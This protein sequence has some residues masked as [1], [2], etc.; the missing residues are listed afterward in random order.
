MTWNTLVE[1]RS[2]LVY[3]NGILQNVYPEGVTSTLD[4]PTVPGQ[5]CYQAVAVLPETQQAS[6]TVCGHCIKPHRKKKGLQCT[7]P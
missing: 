7:V 5:Y 3:V 2:Y 6:N 4:V 1:A